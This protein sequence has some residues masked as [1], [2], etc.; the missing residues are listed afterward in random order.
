MPL[1]NP[2]T[3]SICGDYIKCPSKFPKNALH[4]RWSKKWPL[5]APKKSLKCPLLEVVG[6]NNLKAPKYDLKCPLFEVV[7]KNSLQRP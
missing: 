1:K 2:N 4:L 6:K 5:N 3:P 7:R